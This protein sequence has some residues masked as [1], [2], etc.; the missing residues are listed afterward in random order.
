MHSKLA[1]KVPHPRGSFFDYDDDGGGDDV[2]LSA[3]ASASAW[4]V[5]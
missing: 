5:H 2:S 4:M 3:S 1:S